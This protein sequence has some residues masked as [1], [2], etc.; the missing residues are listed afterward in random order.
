MRRNIGSKHATAAALVVA[1]VLVGV[2]QSSHPIYVGNFCSA[3]E[4]YGAQYSNKEQGESIWSANDVQQF[5]QDVGDTVKCTPNAAYVFA[6]K[7]MTK[8]RDRA[9]CGGNLTPKTFTNEIFN[10]ALSD[11]MTRYYVNT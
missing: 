4:L 11:L 5:I 9:R 7:R 8:E 6:Y 1:F 10:D 2:T 3:S